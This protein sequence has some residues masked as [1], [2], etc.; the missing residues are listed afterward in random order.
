LDNDDVKNLFKN[1]I[2]KKD[3]NEKKSFLKNGFERLD[4]IY[5]NLKNFYK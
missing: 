1:F 4:K 5:F 2:R 3:K